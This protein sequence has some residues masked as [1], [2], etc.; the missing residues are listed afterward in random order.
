M[1]LHLGVLDLPYADAASYK[2]VKRRKPQSSEGSKTT[3]EVATILEE[4]YKVMETFWDANKI[5]IA[6]SLENSFKDA[7]EAIIM[8]A[9]LG[10]DPAGAVTSE[11][12][13]L[14]RE[15]L[16]LKK[17]DGKIPGVPTKAAQKGVSHR[18][19]HPYKKRPPR[20]SFI[21]TGLYEGSMRAWVD[22]D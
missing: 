22:E 8:G 12:E 13:E 21:D 18:F 17:L 3:G 10:L 2:K 20:P 7:L 5:K 19:K 9:P 11:I 4:K 6:K 15:T 1:K 16:T 14:F